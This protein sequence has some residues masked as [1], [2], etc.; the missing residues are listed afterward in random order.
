MV[1]PPAHI[2]VWALLLGNLQA[3]ATRPAHPPMD[4]KLYLEALLSGKNVAGLVN[5]GGQLT[6][7]PQMPVRD[8]TAF[9][10]TTL[11]AMDMD[12]QKG[13]DWM[14]LTKQHYAP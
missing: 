1:L 6:G 7:L 9:L 8:Q 5:A 11:D 13:I 3:Q 4:L 12:N 10:T 2:A 14:M